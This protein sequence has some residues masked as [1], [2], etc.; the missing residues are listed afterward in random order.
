ME[1]NVIF[2]GADHRGFALKQ[3]LVE[4]A[5]TQGWQVKDV[6]PAEL[7]PDD[8]YPDIAAQVAQ[9]VA[10]DSESTSRGVLICGS[11][12]GVALA[13][14]KIPGIRAGHTPTVEAVR[15][16][17]QDED[18]NIMTLS[19]DTTSFEDAQALLTAF[20][21]TPFSNQ[22]RHVRRLAKIAALETVT[23]TP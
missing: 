9:Q 1:N 15:Q 8:D 23:N 5:T 13:A 21:D 11:G 7:N 17:R 6:G 19:G 10:V 12:L 3:Q 16:A 2:I 20:L 14:N 4:W 22:E 18:L